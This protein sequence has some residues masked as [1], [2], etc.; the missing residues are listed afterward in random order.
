MATKGD[1]QTAYGFRIYLGKVIGFISYMELTAIHD[2]IAFTFPR[3]GMPIAKSL[4]NVK[5]AHNGFFVAMAQQVFSQPVLVFD[6]GL[7][8]PK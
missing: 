5:T 7:W 6:S 8:Q 4:K 2:I 1:H 3:W